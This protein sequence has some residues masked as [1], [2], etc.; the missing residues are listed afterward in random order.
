MTITV[1][2]FWNDGNKATQVGVG[3]GTGMGTCLEQCVACKSE[4]NR[5]EEIYY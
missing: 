3:A 1:F 4:L 5:S 2:A